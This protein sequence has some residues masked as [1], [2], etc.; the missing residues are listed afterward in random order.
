M[1]SCLEKGARKLNE[2]VNEI[3]IQ[4]IKEKVVVV[5]IGT[6]RSTGDSLGPFVGTFLSEKQL[7]NMVVFGTIDNPVH[8]VN[9]QEYIDKI[10]ED[11]PKSIVIAIDAS[12]GTE[13][14]IG[15]IKVK[16]Q[17][18][19]PGSALNKDLPCIGDVSITGVVNLS[20]FMEFSVIQSTRLK[21]VLKLA[22][23]IKDLILSVD[24]EITNLINELS[25]VE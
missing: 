15:E 12:L 14:D 13:K 23:E 7:D 6:D 11:Y 25:G 2:V 4:K 22:N 20:G 19:Y 9:L 5:C 16:H 21:I 18:L 10:N 24:K 1:I 3:L 8:A 17:P